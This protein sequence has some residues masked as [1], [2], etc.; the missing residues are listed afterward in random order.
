VL[1]LICSAA[2]AQQ[3]A[4]S[5]IVGEVNDSSKAGVPGATV[6]VTN[7]GTNA[8]RVATTDANGRFSI[9]NLVPATYEIKVELSGFSTIDMKDFALRQGEIAR[10]VFSLNVATVSETVTVTGQ[11]PLLQ[12]Q[13]ASVSQTAG[14]HSRN[15][16]RGSGQQPATVRNRGRRSRQLDELRSRRRI[17]AVFAVQ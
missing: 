1:L 4:S 6:T 5:G 11:S 16:V 10:P 2:H 3:S 13:S 7:V 15:A 9:P 17:C 12:T 14:L 8:Q